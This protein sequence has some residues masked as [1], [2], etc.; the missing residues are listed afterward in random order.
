[1]ISESMKKKILLVLITGLFLFGLTQ[2]VQA[3][4]GISPP[5]FR[6]ENLTRGSHFEQKIILVRGDPVEDWKVEIIPYIPEAENWFSVDRG[7]EFILPKGEKQIPIIISVDVPQSADFG[8]YKGHFRVKT[9]SLKPPEPGTVAIALGGQIDVDLNVVKGR[10]FNFNVKGVKVADAEEGHKWWKFYFPGKIKF[11]VKIENTGNVKGAPT[12]L[13]LDIYDEAKKEV[14]ETL[15]TK[16]FDGMVGPFETKYLT[17]VLPTKLSPGS[18]W[19][20]FKIFKGEEIAPGGEGEIHL[21]VLPYG[22]LPAEPVKLLGLNIWIWVVIGIF[23]LAG[24]GYAGYRGYVW[25]LNRR[26]KKIGEA[27]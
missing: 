19:V 16:K 14:V 6:N 7:R 11:S 23:V 9:S 3:G 21:S 22:T 13:R 10:N 15:E 4:F 27:K 5:E 26:K 12:K 1:M 25:F 8:R 20:R 24:I 2:T 17:A 18:Y